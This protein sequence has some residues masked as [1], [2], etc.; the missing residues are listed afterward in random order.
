MR[1]TLEPTVLCPA[2]ASQDGLIF[3][4]PRPYGLTGRNYMDS[5]LLAL[6]TACSFPEETFHALAS[7]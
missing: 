1:P 7:P 2:S 5:L 3:S 6:H 4:Q